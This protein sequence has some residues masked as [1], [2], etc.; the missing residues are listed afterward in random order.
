MPQLRRAPV[1]TSVIDAHLYAVVNVNAFE[2]VDAALL[3]RT[4]A[5]FD[6]EDEAT[7]LARRARHWIADVQFS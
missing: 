1:V 3:R 5:S 6:A 4:P 2:A 7:R